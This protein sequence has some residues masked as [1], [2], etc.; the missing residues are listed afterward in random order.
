MARFGKRI[1]ERADQ[2]RAHSIG[3]AEPELRL[4]GMDVHVHLLGRQRQ[5][6]RKHG[7]AALRQEIAIGRAHRTGEKLVAYGP[8]IHR[9]IELRG[10]GP[11]QR[12]QPGE[13]LKR[14]VA[15]RGPD[16]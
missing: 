13:A 7:I 4:G 1:T 3:V 5:E 12:R 16:G 10:V 11:M 9:E 2:Q 8:S 15:A 14:D 6:Q